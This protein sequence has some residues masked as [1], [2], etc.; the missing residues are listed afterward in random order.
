MVLINEYKSGFTCSDPLILILDSN[1]KEF[2]KKENTSKKGYI[3]FNLPAGKYHTQ[4]N[5][6][7]VSFRKYD[8]PAIP[9]P[10]HKKETKPF[11]IVF[12][13]NPNK[14]SINTKTG[15][16]IF[17]N[18]FK[19]QPKY[20]IDFIL[21]H[22]Y[23]HYFYSGEGQKSEKNCD[24]YA[25]RQMLRQGYNPSQISIA[26]ATTLSDNTLAMHRK[27]NI[28]NFNKKINGLTARRTNY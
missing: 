3:H 12:D 22:E 21:W 8:L 13:E 19:D 23:A 6:H 5:L 7:R 1:G 15:L 10:N 25:Q 14:C 2:Y 16:V 20:V 17:D 9:K 11:K 4:N 27:N 28:H 24:T 26:I 18:S